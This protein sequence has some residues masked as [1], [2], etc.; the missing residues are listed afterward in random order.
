M[1][2]GAAAA[3]SWDSD[4]L[5]CVLSAIAAPKGDIAVAEAVGEPTPDVAT[6]FMQWFHERRGCP[7]PTR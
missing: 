3:R 6:E 1:L 5:A 4:F 7:T 2:A